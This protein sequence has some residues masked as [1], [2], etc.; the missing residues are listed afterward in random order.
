LTNWRADA[1]SADREFP[2]EDPAMTQLEIAGLGL[3]VTVVYMTCGRLISVIRE[4]AS[5]VDPFWGLGFVL[6]AVIFAIGGEAP[7]AAWLRWWGS[8]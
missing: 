1:D 2:I 6:L 3:L 7:I 4:D 5:T 8:G